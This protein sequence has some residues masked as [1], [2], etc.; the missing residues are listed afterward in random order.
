MSKIG[1]NA[2]RL[3]AIT[4][5]AVLVLG[6]IQWLRPAGSTAAAEDGRLFMDTSY[7]FAERAADLVSRLKLK[8]KAA[9]IRS[10]G[11]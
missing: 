6:G 10:S 9:Q 8:E 7:S 11:P 5:A 1:T 3:L 2:K 4:L